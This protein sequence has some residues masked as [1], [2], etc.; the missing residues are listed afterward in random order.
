MKKLSALLLAAFLTM[1]L[2]F[3]DDVINI[4]TDLIGSRWIAGKWKMFIS[5]SANGEHETTQSDISIY[6]NEANS[7]V[8]ITEDDSYCS[9][10]DYI[11]VLSSLNQDVEIDQETVALMLLMG[12][13]F[14][15]DFNYHF[16]PKGP[17]ITYGFS[18]AYS[19]DSMSISVKIRKTA[20][21]DKSEYKYWTEE[22]YG[23]SGAQ[24]LLDNTEDLSD[25][26]DS[27][28]SLY[29]YEDYDDY[30]D[31]DDEEESDF[32]PSD[33]YDEWYEY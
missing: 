3:A 12:M 16:N 13:A 32:D 1:G 17:E 33:F 24:D 18:L 30:D 21:I 29:D 19:G 27:E 4:N 2:A 26:D 23:E 22:E 10:A 31:Y 6:G 20:T 9:L 25:E 5:I 14:K 11:E 28:D 8:Y 15:G 7:L